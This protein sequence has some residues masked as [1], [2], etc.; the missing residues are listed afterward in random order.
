MEQLNSVKLNT[1]GASGYAFYDNGTKLVVCGPDMTVKTFDMALNDWKDIEDT[2]REYKGVFVSDRRAYLF[3]TANGIYLEGFDL[4]NLKS[5]SSAVLSEA[6]VLD[7]A[8][9]D[10]FVAFLIADGL[11]VL[12]ARDLTHSVVSIGQNCTMV[13]SSFDSDKFYCAGR[14]MGMVEVAL[15]ASGK[16]SAK[17]VGVGEQLPEAGEVLCYCANGQN[18]VVALAGNALYMVDLGSGHKAK[19]VANLD[20]SDQLVYMAWIN[21]KEVALQFSNHITLYDCGGERVS[22]NFDYEEPCLNIKECDSKLYLHD[23][24]GQLNVYSSVRVTPE[25]EQPKEPSIQAQPTNPPLPFQKQAKAPKKPA[26]PKKPENQNKPQ[27]EVEGEKPGSELSDEDLARTPKDEPLDFLLEKKDP[28]TVEEVKAK[29][30][31]LLIEE[32]DDDMA[33][34][35]KDEIDFAEVERFAEEVAGATESQTNGHTD[36]RMQEE[37]V[38][39]EAQAP[40]QNK[41]LFETKL[42]DKERNTPRQRVKAFKYIN[43]DM[44]GAKLQPLVIP[45]SYGHAKEGVS[46]ICLNNFGQISVHQLEDTSTLIVEY[47]DNNL[48]KKQV[49]SNQQAFELADMSLA[50]YVLASRGSTTTDD[51]YEDELDNSSAVLY[52]HSIKFDNEWSVEFNKGDALQLVSLSNQYI[53]V[54]NASNLLRVYSHGGSEVYNFTVDSPVVSIASFESYLSLVTV[55][56]LP[57]FGC[58]QLSL[59]TYDVSSMRLL[60]E[61]KLCV[62]PYSR[63][64]WFGYSDDGVLYTQDSEGCI[65]VLVNR[66]LWVTV[67]EDSSQRRFWLLGIMDND[68]IGYRLGVGETRPNPQMRYS[69]IK[70]TARVYKHNAFDDADELAA[71]TG[72][73]TLRT[74][75]EREKYY[76]YKNIKNSIS[77][78]A[79]HKIFSDRIMAPEELNALDEA[80]DVKR[81][82]LVRNLIVK[83]NKY[84]GV[85]EATQIRNE[86]NFDVVLQLLDKIKQ[87]KMAEELKTVA[88]ESGLFAFLSSHVQQKPSNTVAK[89]Q[90]NKKM[91][92]WMAKE[93]C[94]DE[95]SKNYFKEEQ[96][97]LANT[98]KHENGNSK[99]LTTP[100]PKPKDSKK[101]PNTQNLLLDLNNATSRDDNKKFKKVNKS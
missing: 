29:P 91:E 70:Q 51:E 54:L 37:P 20:V 34:K 92:E 74:Y 8:Q 49:I 95:E 4:D 62:T 98:K 55:S 94:S 69:V 61:T 31:R 6:T 9:S 26:R 32:E 47:K 64:T 96:E 59:K 27:T 67:F 60:Y 50:G 19:Q 13:E 78:N 45:G 44:V 24:A 28:A 100:A 82:E 84:A 38:Q 101:R 99:L 7:H 1:K 72:L 97:R 57:L 90:N 73:E 25:V 11:L 18:L 86:A 2:T 30:K 17:S 76:N 48:H 46:V 12:N 43:D 85:Y 36:T 5:V 68:L 80:A 41:M 87:K 40:E 83:G 88:N 42:A 3:D 79:Y 23:K 75:I 16:F 71:E 77:N 63:L 15:D 81:I 58:Q 39:Q 22:L 66:S 93:T 33:D 56:G 89:K 65:R 14:G 53:F 35:G 10:N 21:D 52:Y